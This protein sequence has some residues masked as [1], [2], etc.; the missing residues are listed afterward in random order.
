MFFLQLSPAPVPPVDS[1]IR[2]AMRHAA[3]R[4]TSSLSALSLFYLFLP[5][6]GIKKEGRVYDPVRQRSL[7]CPLIVYLTQAVVI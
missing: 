3:R 7:D 4:N 2:L 6:L 5:P 1:S